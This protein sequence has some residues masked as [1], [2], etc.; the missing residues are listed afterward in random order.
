MDFKDSGLEWERERPAIIKAQYFVEIVN[1]SV[2]KKIREEFGDDA[3]VSAQLI[4][5]DSRDIFLEGGSDPDM[6]RL[7]DKYDRK[8]AS[9]DIVA[10]ISIRYPKGSDA[11]REYIIDLCIVAALVQKGTRSNYGSL[12]T[13]PN[14]SF[15]KSSVKKAPFNFDTYL[16]VFEFN[17]DEAPPA[18]Q[19]QREAILRQKLSEPYL[20]K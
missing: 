7:G 19:R 17:D 4:D 15:L 6:V 1:G 5:V 20:Y 12:M 14:L 11:I 9:D 16:D 8:T 18:E 3:H 2:A 13:K 10:D